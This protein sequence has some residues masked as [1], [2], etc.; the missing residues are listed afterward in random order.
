MANCFLLLFLCVFFWFTFKF[1][2]TFA[3]NS[4]SSPIPFCVVVIPESCRFLFRWYQRCCFVLHCYFLWSFIQTTSYPSLQ[5]HCKL[6]MGIYNCIW[7]QSAEFKCKDKLT[8]SVHLAIRQFQK[9]LQSILLNSTTTKI[10]K[11]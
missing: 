11:T 7:K 6:C 3:L 2:S 9:F 8:Y 5:W 1:T 4:D 10:Y